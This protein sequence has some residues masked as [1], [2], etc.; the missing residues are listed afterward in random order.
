MCRS[1]SGLLSRSGV[2][3]H[4]HVRGAAAVEHLC[5][6]G[7]ARRRLHRLERLVG[8]EAVARQVERPESH[9]HL[10]RHRGRVVLHIGGAAHPADRLGH[11]A[12]RQVEAVEVVAKEL[13][14]HLRRRARQRLLDP[15]GQ[16]AADRKVHPRNPLEHPAEVILHRLGRPARE[17]HQV[18]LELGVVRPPGVLRQLG[19]PRPLRHQP[20]P[21]VGAAAGRRPACRGAPTHRVTCPALPTCG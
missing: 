1:C 2:E 16:E 15:L 20:H 18:H 7:T 21:W 17:R 4:H 12:R 13:D 14:D 11:A 19:T 10:R 8:A 5:H 9:R 6:R 3:D